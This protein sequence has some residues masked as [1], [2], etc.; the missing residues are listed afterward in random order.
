MALLDKI[1]GAKDKLER[2]TQQKKAESRARERR[3]DIGE[4]EGATETAEVAAK[5]TK[6]LGGQAKEFVGAAVPGGASKGAE[7]A[8]GLLSSIG[9]GGE[10]VLDDIESGEGID[11]IDSGTGNDDGGLGLDG[12]L[13]AD[14]SGFDDDLNMLD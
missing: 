8:G 4:P 1:R 3:I 14:M 12:D 10:N 2:A 6:E 5:E 11:V 7:K 13:G 9:E